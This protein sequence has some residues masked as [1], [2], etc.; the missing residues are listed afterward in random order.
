[1]E[2]ILPRKVATWVPSATSIGIAFCIPAW[3]GIST[4]IGAVIAWYLSKRIESW[5]KK[6]LIVLAAGLIAG[7]SLAGATLAVIETIGG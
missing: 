2:K 4:A 7:E 5:S 6:F 1:M 3:I